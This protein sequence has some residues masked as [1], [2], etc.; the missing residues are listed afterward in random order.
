MQELKEKNCSYS[1]VMENP[2]VQ[3]LVQLLCGDHSMNAATSVHE[4]M[5]TVTKL[6][7]DIRNQE[8]KL[9]DYFFSKQ[10]S[11]LLQK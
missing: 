2:L 8:E 1:L 7:K 3:C 5:S 6:N 9:F 11:V 4:L 10:M